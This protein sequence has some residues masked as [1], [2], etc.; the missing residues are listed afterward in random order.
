MTRETTYKTSD[1]YNNLLRLIKEGNIIIGLV[2]EK[3]NFYGR[4]VKMEYLCTVYMECNIYKIFTESLVQYALLYEGI[5][6]KHEEK[7]IEKCGE[8]ELKYIIP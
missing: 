6:G 1:D 3:K 7:F 5:E 4:S 8:L 2:F